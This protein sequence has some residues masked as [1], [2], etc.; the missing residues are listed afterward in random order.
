MPMEPMKTF[1]VGAD[2][3]EIVDGAAREELEDARTGADGTEY[4]SAGEAMR[5]S[6]NNINDDLEANYA[7]QDGYYEML[8]AGSA[9]NLTGRGD[10]VGA[11]F[12]YRTAGGSADIADGVA[13]IQSVK[14]N[15]LV[16]N[17]RVRPNGS[18]TGGNSITV[19]GNGTYTIGTLE[20]VHYINALDNLASMAGHKAL[21][22]IN[23]SGA[24]AADIVFYFEAE[25]YR[26]RTTFNAS[27]YSGRIVELPSNA[28]APT[29]SVAIG[30]YNI[31]IKPQFFD[32]TRMFGAGNEPATVAEFEALFPE[33]YYP[34]DAGSLLNV[35]MEGVRTVGFNQWDEEWELGAISAADGTN[36]VNNNVIRTKGYIPVIPNAT[37]Y[38]K[39]GNGFASSTIT[40]RYYDADKNYIGYVD[41]NGNTNGANIAA[42]RVMPSNCHYMRF[43]LDSAYGKTYNN[44]ICI[45][46]SWSGY[47]NGEYEPYWTQERAIDTATYFPDGMKSA[48]S[49]HDE[50]TATKAV[51]RVGVVDLGALDYSYYT[52]GDNPMFYTAISGMKLGTAAQL[53]AL[54]CAIYEAI[55]SRSR[56]SFTTNAANMQIAVQ[57][58]NANVMIRNDSYTDANTFKTAM[59]G[60]MLYYELSEPVETE[61]TPEL[62]LTYK[63]SDF[64]TEEIIV[65]DNEQTAPV[66]M[67]IVYGLNAVDTIRRLPVEYI[68]HKSFMQFMSAIES[69]FNVT[70]TETYD[71]D[72]ERYNYSIADNATNESGE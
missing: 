65:A 70:I 26:N 71:S 7:L 17:Q 27:N 42:G 39:V 25:T 46:L 34:Y 31:D 40:P 16:W 8:T 9:D 52:S 12:I 55:T 37:Y 24:P 1:T 61:I 45:N 36:A 53:S 4:E 48:G 67:Q 56:A 57:S 13:K 15:T 18:I 11:E 68:S 44:D 30:D 22:K 66:C 35:N 33:T 19:N 63:V 64:G 32:L 21:V 2:T 60:V 10:G 43:G 51:K 69:H 47:R 28:G 49:V 38:F 20:T 14:G 5:E 72:N 3:W 58:D 6:V 41:A 59:S 54:S 23:A 62:N 29:I 50:L